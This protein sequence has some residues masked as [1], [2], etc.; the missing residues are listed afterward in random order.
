MHLRTVPPGIPRLRTLVITFLVAVVFSIGLAGAAWADDDPG[1]LSISGTILELGTEVAV[2]DATVTLLRSQPFGTSGPPSGAGQTTT[3]ED[4][5]YAFRDVESFDDR[6]Y[7]VIV[8][9]DGYDTYMGEGFVYDGSAPV[10][11]DVLLEP[12][13]GDPVVTGTVI[14]A[15]TGLPIPQ[16]TVWV[17]YDPDSED[18]DGLP[19]REVEEDGTFAFWDVE[20]DREFEVWAEAEVAGYPAS[21][22]EVLLYDGE[23]PLDVEI[24]LTRQLE[25]RGIDFATEFMGDF[26]SGL[27]DIGHLSAEAQAAIEALAF[28]GVTI[29]CA[30]GT[31]KPG[32]TVMR[33][34]M[35]LFLARVIQYAV[36]TGVVETPAEIVD[37]GFSDTS[38]LSQE[39][40]DAI[41]LLYTLGVTQ[42][43]TATTFSPYADV[44]RRDMASFMVRLQNLLGQDSY[45]TEGSFFSDVP[46]TMPR[47][48]D[49]NALAAQ[50]IAVG[51]GDGTYGPDASVLRSQMALF[52]MRHIDENVEA[53]RLPA[54][55]G[56]S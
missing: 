1:Q 30:D 38:A 32:E 22:S 40:K 52:I 44:T 15:V 26:A 6:N 34:Q 2:A 50:G 49:I 43:T 5:Y 28:Y 16:A 19:G 9:A 51:Y 25:A 10:V 27:T 8:E 12:Q 45:A 23:N 56:P 11:V 48:A 54:L 47:A 29:G 4:G 20:P 33:S 36:D 17:W 42:G 35:A 37:P 31:Y 13:L 55:G 7:S 21:M 14:D 41:A 24:N 53:G 3:D 18:H 39:A 46:D